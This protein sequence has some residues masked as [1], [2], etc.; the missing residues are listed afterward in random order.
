MVRTE[1]S[2]KSFEC[3]TG[4]RFTVWALCVGG[5]V[6]NGG[7]IQFYEN[8]TGKPAPL[9]VSGFQAI[10]RND[11][12]M[13]VDESMHRAII[14]YPKLAKQHLKIQTVESEVRS[15]DELDEAY[16]DL[17]H[18]EDI[19]WL[20]LEMIKLVASRPDIF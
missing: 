14:E 12:V 8:T 4:L 9:A 11:F 13:I 17:S 1:S 19:N 3:Q 2:R 5:Q 6:C 15:F 7:F 16:F 10:G 20:E 18:A